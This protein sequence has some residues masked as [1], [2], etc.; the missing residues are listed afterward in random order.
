MKLRLLMTSIVIAS[1]ARCISYAQ[2]APPTNALNFARIISYDVVVKDTSTL[3]HNFKY[4]GDS[5]KQINEIVSS[6]STQ[7]IDPLSFNQF[8]HIIKK[9]LKDK[10]AFAVM[11]NKKV[12]TAELKQKL[13]P[14]DSVEAIMFNE[15]G[16]E[17]VT[18]VQACDSTS[19]FANTKILH[20]E[21]SWYIDPKTYE[22]KK[23]V[24]S[25]SLIYWDEKREFWL[26]K[27]TIYKNQA[28]FDKIK[29]LTE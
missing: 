28:A 8:I 19:M 26:S 14:C 13:F 10:N 11:G 7:Y 22:F 4:Y 1:F 15:R 25:F 16:D 24:L 27:L 2:T 5:L 21:E 9:Y 3:K 18:K 23:E 12:K 6:N 29:A 17:I 20:F